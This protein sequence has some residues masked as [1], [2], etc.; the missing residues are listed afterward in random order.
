[1]KGMDPIPE[2]DQVLL[3]KLFRG[4]LAVSNLELGVSKL[5][6]GL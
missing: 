4:S 3:G 2:P 1:M 5:A 6:L